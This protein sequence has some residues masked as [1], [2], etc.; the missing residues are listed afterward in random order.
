MGSCRFALSLTL[1][2]PTPSTALPPSAAASPTALPLPLHRLTFQADDSVRSLRRTSRRLVLRAR[3]RPRR[4]RLV[5]ARSTPVCP[6]LHAPF[7]RRLN[8]VHRRA[9]RSNSPADDTDPAVECRIG[10]RGHPQLPLLHTHRRRR[11]RRTSRAPVAIHR[12]PR[13][14]CIASVSLVAQ[15][16]LVD[17]IR[18]LL[19]SPF[20]CLVVGRGPSC[21]P[22]RHGTPNQSRTRDK[23]EDSGTQNSRAEHDRGRARRHAC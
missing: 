15:F 1:S 21:R 9:L 13:L 23:R 3:P 7:P 4:P 11:E 10:R 8:A 18:R 20:L 19:F 12:H 2:S 22:P 17:A 16:G 14:H 5:S 6:A